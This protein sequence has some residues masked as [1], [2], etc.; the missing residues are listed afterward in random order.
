MIPRKLKKEQGEV[1]DREKDKMDEKTVKNGSM[2]A[3]KKHDIVVEK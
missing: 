3:M 2:R 1:K